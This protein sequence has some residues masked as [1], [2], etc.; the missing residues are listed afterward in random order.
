MS[1]ILVMNLVMNIQL[2]YRRVSFRIECVLWFLIKGGNDVCHYIIIYI[3]IY[4]QF[5]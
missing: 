3:I 1:V 2:I 5:S 4:L